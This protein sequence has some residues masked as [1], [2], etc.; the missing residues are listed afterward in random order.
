MDGNGLIHAF[1]LDGNGG[2]R[3]LCWD[4]INSWTPGKG[5]LWLHLSYTSADVSSWLHE[6][7]GLES[8]V[9]EALL[10]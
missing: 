9:V 8:V 3:E 5:I 6:N 10:S 1:I 2:G 7:S 4:E